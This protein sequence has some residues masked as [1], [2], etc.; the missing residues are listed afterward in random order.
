MIEL[1]ILG[2]LAEGPL[3]GYILRKRME[4]L[5]GSARPISYGTLY[6]AINRLVAARLVRQSEEP[7]KAGAARQVLSL[8]FPGRQS[9]EERLRGATG[10]DIT[11][12]QRFT[13][14]LAFL[15]HLPDIAQRDAVL[16]RRLEFLSKPPA[17]FSDGERPL[18][19]DEVTD[20]YRKGILVTAEAAMNAETEWLTAMLAPG[21]SAT[22]QAR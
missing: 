17:F 14:V 1:M 5:Y 21:D 4:M 10:H 7:G 16:R 13:V 20:P 12:G 6:P 19:A 11:D 22:V 15:S 3:H 2:F 8:T 18:D 9:L